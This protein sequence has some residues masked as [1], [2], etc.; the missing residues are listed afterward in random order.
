MESMYI[1]PNPAKNNFT[2]SIPWLVSP[3]KMEIYNSVGEITRSV[4]INNILTDINIGELSN[5]IYFVNVYT[6]KGILFKK[7]IK[8]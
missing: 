2:I 6:E 8:M 3:L 5:G 7:L 4:L 1:Y